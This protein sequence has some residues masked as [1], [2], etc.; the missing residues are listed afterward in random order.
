MCGCYIPASMKFNIVKK[1]QKMNK[2][3]GTF[4]E[5]DSEKEWFNLYCLFLELEFEFNLRIYD[6]PEP[7]ESSTGPDILK[8]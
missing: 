2:I 8:G 4:L 7:P 6:V 5:D 1:I 3:R